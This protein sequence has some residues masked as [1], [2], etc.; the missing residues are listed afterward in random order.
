MKVEI[1]DSFIEYGA[2]YCKDSISMDDIDK[3]L[4]DLIQMDDEHGWFFVGVYGTITPEFV[5]EL[6]KNLT[7]FLNL[8]EDENYRIKLESKEL[9]RNF[10]HLLLSG[11]IGGLKKEILKYN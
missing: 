1:E 10:F 6:D 11:N 9:A 4:T 5:L 2:G 3:A 8:S 7:L